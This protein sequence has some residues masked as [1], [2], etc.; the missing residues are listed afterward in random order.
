[1]KLT[2]REVSVLAAKIQKDSIPIITSLQKASIIKYFENEYSNFEKSSDK[3]VFDKY[4]IK[5][6]NLNIVLKKNRFTVRDRSVYTTQYNMKA[7]FTAMREKKAVLLNLYYENIKGLKEI[8]DAIILAQ[9]ESQD[10]LTLK[11]KVKELLK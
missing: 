8:E 10:L 11:E 1:M 3:K 7:S 2:K 6:P 4:N 5:S 9:M